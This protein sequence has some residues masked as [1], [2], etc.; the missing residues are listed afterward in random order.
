MLPL[1]RRRQIALDMARAAI[2][3]ADPRT[4]VRRAIEATDDALRVGT[5]RAPWSDVGRAIVVGAG[6]AAWPMAEAAEEALGDRLAAG[7]VVTKEGHG[8]SPG[9]QARRRV[10]IVEAGHPVPDERGVR[11][12]DELLHLVS[13]LSPRDVVIVLLSGGGS[14]LLVAPA[15]GITLADK[16]A[17]TGLLLASGATIGEIN[18]VR[19]HLSRVKGGQLVRACA[20][21]RVVALALSDVIGDPLD[22]IASGPTV[23][24]PTTYV[25][26]LA[27]LDR[28]GLRE[29]VPPNVVARF[30]QGAAGALPE[31]PKADDPAFA[32]AATLLIGTNRVALDAA[33]RTAEMNGYRP[34]VLTSSLRGEAREVAKV[35]CALAEGVAPQDR[36][37]ALV[38]G[39]ETTVTLSPDAG[40]GGRNQELALAA[41]IEIA[42]RDDVVILSMG[43]DGTD[44]PTDAAGG[45]A[46]GGTVERARDAGCSPGDALRRHDAYPLLEATGDL[47][48]T[49]PTGTNVMDVVIALVG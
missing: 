46:D 39:G 36:P 9:H 40:R 12:A 34:R 22:V 44:G 24:D 26:A 47:I 11:A 49:G 8:A 29:K 38:F 17:T 28:Y 2:A 31:T 13:G 1:D 14:A 27:V 41:A 19:K 32:R 5:W 48:V 15:E 6:K 43:T 35:I 16:Q 45:I 33:A 37:A 20:P 7:L 30:V 42:G 21:A 4:T 3:A 10:R 25:D 18:C 23:P